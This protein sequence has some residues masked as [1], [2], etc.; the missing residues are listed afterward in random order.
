MSHANARLNVHGRR[1]LVDRVRRQ[2]W[3]VAHAA[4]AMGISRQCAH[5]WV[6][7][8]DAEGESGLADRS[9]RPRSSPH[10]TSGVVEAAIVAARI[11]R[12]RGP[13]PATRRR[14]AILVR[15]VHDVG[16]VVPHDGRCRAP[17]GC[18]AP[19]RLPSAQRSADRERRH[20]TARPR[21]RLRPGVPPQLRRPGPGQRSHP[22][23]RGRRRRAG[24]PRAGEHGD[25]GDGGR[26]PGRVRHLPRPPGHHVDRQRVSRPP[27]PRGS[28]RRG[29]GRGVGSR[30]GWDR[31]LGRGHLHPGGER[32]R[33]SR[34]RHRY[35]RC[36]PAGGSGHRHPPPG[37]ASGTARSGT[38][39][40]R[41]TGPRPWSDARPSSRRS[42]PTASARVRS[43]TATGAL[44]PATRPCTA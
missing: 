8:F 41:P 32:R 30:V 6:A 5:R 12:R 35:G 23:H 36:R 11:P 39:P 25:R 1:L 2:G 27:A 16:A 33:R 7:R 22:R 43:T 19:D 4:K 42:R 15:C 17:R 21:G 13:T 40:G 34:G 14:P 18:L 29:R 37:R 38:S 9:S 24:V 28:C 3:A 26:A 10:R 31:L 44:A 20:P